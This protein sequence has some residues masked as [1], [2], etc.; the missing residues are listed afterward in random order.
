MNVFKIL[1]GSLLLS[2]M[3]TMA[4][5]AQSV[6]FAAKEMTLAQKDKDKPKERP[7]EREKEKKDDRRDERRDDK[8]K[9]KKPDEQG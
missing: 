2:V 6:N 7:V 1:I 8:D 4:S 3:L 9:K 5:V